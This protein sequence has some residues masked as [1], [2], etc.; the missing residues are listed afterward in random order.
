MGA[1]PRVI[2]KAVAPAASFE[3]RTLTNRASDPKRE[4]FSNQKLFVCPA[5]LG[6]DVWFSCAYNSPCR[7]KKSTVVGEFD[8]IPGASICQAADVHK[9]RAVATSIAAVFLLAGCSNDTKPASTPPVTAADNVRVDLSKPTFVNG[10]NISNP[11]FPV[12]R[13]QSVVSLG[14]IDGAPLRTETALLNEQ[15]SIAWEAKTF[16]TVVTQTVTYEGTHLDQIAEDY[17]AQSDDGSVWT[18]GRHVDNYENGDIRNTDG[19][20]TAGNDAPPAMVMPAIPQNGVVFRSKNGRGNIFE[21]TTIQ[22]VGQ[23]ATAPVG[24][25]VDAV[26]ASTLLYSGQ[27]VPKTYVANYGEVTRGAGRN[28][29]S[30]AVSVPTDRLS[31]PVPPELLAISG[32][33]LQIVLSAQINDWATA[34]AVLDNLNGNWASFKATQTAPI[35]LDAQMSSAL[36]SV[37]GWSLAPALAARDLMGVSQGALDVALAAIDLQLRYI[38]TIEADT[39]RV[40]LLIRQMSLDAY[41]QNE[42]AVKGD[43]AAIDATMKRLD[44]SARAKLQPVIDE[45]NKAKDWKAIQDAL[46]PLG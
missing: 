46:I 1:K 5:Q 22:T 31:A 3:V 8:G 14:L 37:T 36:S 30:M 21:E 39:A 23:P 27:R 26:N 12:L 15:K 16:Q 24:P 9:R 7:S 19:S 33:A 41:A 13:R 11:L 44:D 20:W 4:S 28:F 2:A 25:V 29:V 10:T 40:K 35:M 34:T 43:R 18:F 32:G 45:T 6:V 38:P 17:Y 42:Y